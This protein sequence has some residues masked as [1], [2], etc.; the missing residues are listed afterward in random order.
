MRRAAT[1]DAVLAAY[2]AA[3]PGTDPT[4]I[5][6]AHQEAAR[7]Y[8]G[9]YR[10]S[11]HPYLTHPVA[12]AATVARLGADR[13]V[14][15]AALL[16]D[17]PA[18][19][20]ALGRVA[21]L[22]GERVA[23]L[24]SGLERLDEHRPEFAGA[25]TAPRDVLLLKLADRLH[26]LRTLRYLPIAKQLRKSEETRRLLVPLARRLGLNA[27]G[28]ELDRLALDVL[29]GPSA[30]RRRPAS[31]LLTAAVVLLPGPARARWAEEWVGEL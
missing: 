23:D 8:R 6:R 1:L 7:W 30:S 21:T 2:A 13:D 19:P 26:N 9:R 12:V 14:V 24:V 28:R 16:H 25:T 3:W 11:G 17:V 29:R 18:T 22:F 10:R 5:R 15:C 31:R 4:P 20:T 27:L